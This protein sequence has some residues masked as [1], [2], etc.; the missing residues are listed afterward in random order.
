MSHQAETLFEAI[1]S[2]Q[3]EMMSVKT[4]EYTCTCNCHVFHCMQH[5]VVVN[6]YDILAHTDNEWG[7]E[8]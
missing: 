4:E 5:I 8:P 6:H 1:N 7:S 3:F 2:L